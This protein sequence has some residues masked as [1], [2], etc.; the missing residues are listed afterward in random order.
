M[1]D[2]QRGTWADGQPLDEVRHHQH[3]EQDDTEW[4]PRQYS[5]SRGC[6]REDE[7][8]FRSTERNENAGARG[9]WRYREKHQPARAAACNEIAEES[10]RRRCAIR[11]G[12]RWDNSSGYQ[13]ALT[14]FARASRDW[15]CQ[16]RSSMSSML[17]SRCA[18]YGSSPDQ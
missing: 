7:P 14:R 4:V 2:P 12:N 1:E 10:A 11:S 13:E 17:H 9:Q 8:A 3:P 6:G 5:G 18:S 16:D 15:S